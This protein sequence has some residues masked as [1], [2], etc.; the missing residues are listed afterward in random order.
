MT[1][2]STQADR[3]EQL[4]AG[5]RPLTCQACGTEVLVRKQSPEQT[6]VQWRSD[7]A[8]CCPYLARQT[9]AAPPMPGCPALTG[10][11]R[12]AALAGLIPSGTQ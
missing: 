8:T 6:S 2:T 11:I 10:T 5:F 7:A 1:L 3:D 4:K 12:A 9:P